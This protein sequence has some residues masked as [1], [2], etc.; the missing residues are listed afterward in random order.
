MDARFT[1]RQA[2]VRKSKVQAAKRQQGKSKKRKSNTIMEEKNIT[3]KI[4][5]EHTTTCD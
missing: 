4:N 1:D 2:E 3:M 5:Q